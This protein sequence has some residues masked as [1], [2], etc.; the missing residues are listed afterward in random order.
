[1]S[2]KQNTN[3]LLKILRI[4]A[5]VVLS[6]ILLFIM[7]G[8][9]IVCYNHSKLLPLNKGYYVKDAYISFEYN[10]VVYSTNTNFADGN[11]LFC[12]YHFKKTT[13]EAIHVITGENKLKA[14]YQDFKVFAVEDDPNGYVF[15]GETDLFAGKEYYSENIITP[16]PE[17][18]DIR[19]IFISNGFFYGEDEISITDE[20][21]IDKIIDCVR[22]N[23]N[24]ETVLDNTDFE[25]NDDIRSTMHIIVDYADFPLYQLIYDETNPSFVC[26]IATDCAE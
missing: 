24:P 13:A 17:T 5:I 10:D 14:L 20:K 2:K 18:N 26:P 1:M 15:K 19:Q 4:A 16:T 6:L 12:C 7:I 8:F 9:G 11:E 25:L 23:G 3:I 21:L 22:S